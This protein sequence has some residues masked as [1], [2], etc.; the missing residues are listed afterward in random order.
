MWRWVAA[1]IEDD[2]ETAERV[3]RQIGDCPRCLRAV[4]GGLAGFV[5]GILI[6]RAGRDV[7]LQVAQHYLAEVLSSPEII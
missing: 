2:D 1:L 3:Q 5:G 7:P 6:D 4:A